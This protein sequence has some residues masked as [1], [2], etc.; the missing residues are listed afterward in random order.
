MTPA[1]YVT[2]NDTETYRLGAVLQQGGTWSQIQCISLDRNEPARV[3]RVCTWRNGWAMGTKVHTS[4]ER[5]HFH[6]N[7]FEGDK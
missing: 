1:T 6:R 5:L 4:G 2:I 7:G 3:V